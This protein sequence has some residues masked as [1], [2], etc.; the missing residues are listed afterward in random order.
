MKSSIET[1]R[2]EL[3]A[4]CV[5]GEGIPDIVSQVPAIFDTLEQLIRDPDI[6]NQHRTLVFAA[7]GYFFIP[8]DLFPEEELGQVGFIDDIILSLCILHEIRFTVQG[9]NAIKRHWK[10]KITIEDALG[11][12][13]SQLIKDYPVEYSTTLNHF[14]LL[15]ITPDGPI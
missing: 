8:D 7:L 14:G 3:S 1:Y 5:G 2:A 13:L 12:H 11:T 4:S 10:L 6:T 15:P 9:N